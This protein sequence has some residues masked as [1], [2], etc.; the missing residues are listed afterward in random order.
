[1]CAQWF[2]WLP[3]EPPCHWLPSVLRINKDVNPHA[4]VCS[5]QQYLYLNRNGT[6]TSICAIDTIPQARF[7]HVA[8]ETSWTLFSSMQRAARQ[9]SRRCARAV[10]ATAVATGRHLLSMHLKCTCGEG[11]NI[12]AYATDSLEE[13]H[14]TRAEHWQK[15]GTHNAHRNISNDVSV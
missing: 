12:A 2:S 8:A 14:L 4:P 3:F 11:R 10:L 6:I 13:C 9:S 15:R 7:C 1:M 5:T